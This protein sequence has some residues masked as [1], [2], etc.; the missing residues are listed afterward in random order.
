AQLYQRSGEGDKEKTRQ[1]EEGTRGR[2]DK[3]TGPPRWP[4]FPLS[5]LP[6]Y[7]LGGVVIFVLGSSNFGAAGVTRCGGRGASIGGA[8]CRCVEFTEPIR[9]SSMPVIPF[10]NSTKPLPSI[11]PISGSLRP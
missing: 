11:L 5:P 9:S 6:Y 4:L 7:A 2:G 8:S 1:G 10:L 3:K